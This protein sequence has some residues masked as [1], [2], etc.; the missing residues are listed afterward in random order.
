MNRV[1]GITRVRCCLVG[2]CTRR[3]IYRRISILARSGASSRLVVAM[4]CRRKSC[5]ILVKTISRISIR[6]RADSS[7]LGDIPVMSIGGTASSIHISSHT[8]TDATVISTRNTRIKRRRSIGLLC[9]ACLDTIGILARIAGLVAHLVQEVVEARCEARS[10]QG[11]EEV[12][13]EVV[14]E[15]VVDDGW[16]ERAGKVERTTGV[17]DTYAIRLVL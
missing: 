10:E 3:L 2:V 13:P 4:A 11:A 8:I 16:A 6:P 17:V 5:I 14:R 15:A 1:Q 12:D 7:S 9:G